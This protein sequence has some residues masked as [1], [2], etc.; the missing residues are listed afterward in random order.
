MHS[1]YS[2]YLSSGSF[3]DQDRIEACKYFIDELVLAVEKG[4]NNSTFQVLYITES[5]VDSREFNLMSSTPSGIF[6][7]FAEFRISFREKL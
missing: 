3:S 2:L 5:I 1:I 7:S 6:E 4:V